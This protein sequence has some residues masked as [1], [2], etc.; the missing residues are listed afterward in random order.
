[1]NNGILMNFK[2]DFLFWQSVGSVF[3]LSVLPFFSYK[4]LLFIGN[5][6]VFNLEFSLSIY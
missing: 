2:D 6:M 4:K 5:S 3:F 1:M